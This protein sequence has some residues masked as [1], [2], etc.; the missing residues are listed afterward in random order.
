MRKSLLWAA[1]AALALGAVYAA[2]A[3]RT[4]EDQEPEHP[5]V[6]QV[7]YENPGVLYTEARKVGIKGL[8]IMRL[9]NGQYALG[10]RILA[11]KEPYESITLYMLFGYLRPGAMYPVDRGKIENIVIPDVPTD[12]PREFFVWPLRQGPPTHR[13]WN[14]VLI[15]LWEI[16][17]PGG[18]KLPA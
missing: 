1:L 16:Q 4:G 5:K 3:A 7:V 15:R 6:V 13:S 14:H 2:P 17:R 12:E 10:G 8:R 18:R 9:K 11:R